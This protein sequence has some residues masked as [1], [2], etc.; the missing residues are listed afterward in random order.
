MRPRVLITEPIIPSVIEKLNKHYSV[1]VGDRN[2]YNSEENLIAAVPDYDALLSML[3]NPITKGVI[4]AGKRL[5]IIAN[6]AVGYNNI[7]VGAA[8]SRNILVANTPGVL[9]DACA[10]FTLGLMLTVSRHL[11]D[12]QQYLL[13]G[14]YHTWEPLGFLG[15]ELK[16]STL[17]IIGLG[18]IGQAVAQR[19]KAFGM[20]ILYHNRNKVTPEIES[21]LHARYC[22]SVEELSSQADIISL[23]CPLTEETHHLINEKILASMPS[24]AILINTSRGPVVD[25]AALAKALHDKTIGGA[26]LD[27]FEKEPEIHPALKKAPN[28]IITPHIAS[29]TH[30]TRKAIGMLAAD[31]IIKALNNK[32]R[33][34]I[35]NLIQ[36]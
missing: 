17:G 21:N 2:T 36:P 20:K 18:R 9:S 33:Q 30:Q 13:N 4:T 29:A 8:R 3:S 14:K 35:P 23:H 16:E 10:E 28:C 31:A 24:H 19:A 7:D 6:H 32:P 25:E 5:K 22:A 15:L 27:V 34:E 26:G 1:D 12:A 11:F